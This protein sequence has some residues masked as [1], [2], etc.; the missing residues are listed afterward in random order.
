MSQ[1][2]PI[3][4]AL[5]PQYLYFLISVPVITY[6]VPFTYYF[7]F[8]LRVSSFL[9][10][11]R[12]ISVTQLS[13]SIA[14]CL[15]FSHLSSLFTTSAFYSVVISQ[16]CLLISRYFTV[17]RVV[18]C[19]CCCAL[20]LTM[21]SRHVWDLALLFPPLVPPRLLRRFRSSSFDGYNFIGRIICFRL[22]SPF[23]ISRDSP[24]PSHITIF[25]K[26]LD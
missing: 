3:C 7:P 4:T 20:S 5:I 22:F 1:T 21:L 14:V 17:S 25:S 16:C 11:P 13:V 10:P 24:S 15:G 9:P 23:Y 2:I 6:N 18:S 26:Y 12:R 8:L 19:S